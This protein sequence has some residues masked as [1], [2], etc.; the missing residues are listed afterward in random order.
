M[1]ARG[2]ESTT[3]RQELE[4]L[5]KENRDLREH[6][7]TSR[8]LEQENSHLK[9]KLMHV[10]STIIHL[11]DIKEAEYSNIHSIL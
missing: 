5:L 9:H 7:F 6:E 11:W 3:L 8:Q 1:K 10:N 2:D 4:L